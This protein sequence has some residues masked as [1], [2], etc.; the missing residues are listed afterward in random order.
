[1]PGRRL[2][3]RGQLDGAGDAQAFLHRREEEA[4]L[5][6]AD[7]QVEAHIVGRHHDVIA[8]LG[9]QRRVEAQQARQLARGA[10]GGD[11]HGLGRQR[12]DR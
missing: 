9:D 3:R 5:G 2:V 11:D 1:M 7:R 10:A 12:L 4:A 8:A 6:R